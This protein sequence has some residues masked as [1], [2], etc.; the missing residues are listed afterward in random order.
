VTRSKRSPLPSVVEEV[1]VDRS[2][3]ARIVELDRVIVVLF[4]GTLGL[5]ATSLPIVRIKD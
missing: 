4:G 5:E 3:E 2:V 1:G